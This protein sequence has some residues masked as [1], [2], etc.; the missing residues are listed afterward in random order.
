M[1]GHALDFHLPKYLE[2]SKEINFQ[3]EC[4]SNTSY[5]HKEEVELGNHPWYHD[6]IY[7]L[8]NQNV[9]KNLERVKK[10]KLRLDASKYV[11]VGKYLFQKYP[12]VM[13]LR[14]VDD[15]STNEILK[16]LHVSSK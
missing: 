11:F 1:K 4:I 16:S 9:L 6:I 8:V 14:C 2:D 3:Q 12:E 10:R 13:L 5:I 7:Y 15:K